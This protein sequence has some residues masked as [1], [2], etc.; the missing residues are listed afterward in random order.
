MLKII[1][2]HEM[3]SVMGLYIAPVFNQGSILAYGLSSTYLHKTCVSVFHYNVQL[4]MFQF[5]FKEVPWLGLNNAD[6]NEKK[7]GSD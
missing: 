5:V 3:T 7:T 4:V 2:F 1:T 6:S